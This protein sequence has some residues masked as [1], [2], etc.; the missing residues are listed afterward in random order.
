MSMNK[1]KIIAASVSAALTGVVGILSASAQTIPTWDAS[2][3][4]AV[5]G[6][7]ADAFQDTFVYVLQVIAPFAIIVGLIV[8]AVWF[9]RG[10][11]KRMGH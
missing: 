5:V 11:G 3:T 4:T 2:S 8:V 10:L 9:F 1:L 6:A 7:A